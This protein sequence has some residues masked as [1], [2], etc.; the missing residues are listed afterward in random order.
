MN[1]RITRCRPL[2]GTFVEV[3][4][5]CAAIEAA[6][7]AIEQVHVLMSAHGRDSDVGRINRLSH[8][9]PVEVDPATAAVLERAL[10]W[11]KKSAGAFDVAAA[12]AAAIDR[13][14]LPLHGAQPKP[15]SA[16]WTCLEL[17]GRT[18]RL[19]KPACIDLGGIAKGYAVDRALAAMK[20]EGATFGFVN[21]GGDI[22]GFGPQPWPVE[23]VEPR[24]RRAIA[25]LAV[26][27]GAI[28]TSSLQPDGSARHLLSIAPGLVSATVCAPCAMDADALTKIVLSGS[29][30][31]RA[32]LR[33]AGA[34]ALLL[35]ADGELRAVEAEPRA[36]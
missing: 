6:F 9:A 14:Y 4:G 2:L 7:R 23:L 21:A 5:R 31:A 12:G 33:S 16:D 10:H 22:A 30:A 34:Q 17:C 13:Q 3:T 18:V 11:S 19:R 29:P 27:N 25:N 28:A 8:Q 36:A 20:A 32:C 26:S 24:S 35:R 15:Q 1:E